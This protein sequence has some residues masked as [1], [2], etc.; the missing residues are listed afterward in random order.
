MNWGGLARLTCRP[1]PRKEPQW[2][3]E[4]HRNGVQPTNDSGLCALDA[5]AR[6]TPGGR[7]AWV[8]IIAVLIA[9]V[10][11]VGGSLKDEFEIPGRTRRRRPT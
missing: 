6:H 9:L 8:G 3:R 11:G 2:R 10:A 7:L 1:I 5:R 4:R